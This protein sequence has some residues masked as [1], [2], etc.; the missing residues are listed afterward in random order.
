MRN[1]HQ[2]E[3][4]SGTWLGAAIKAQ[5]LG[6]YRGAE[7]QK[8]WPISSAAAGLGQKYA[9]GCTPAG[10]HRVRALIGAKAPIDSVFVARRLTGETY[11]PALAQQAPH[12]DWILSRIIWLTGAESGYNRGG[13][14]DTLRRFIYIHGT[15]SHEPM[16]VARSH[17]CLRMR[18]RDV[19][20]LFAHCWP[21]MPVLIDTELPC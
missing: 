7:C 4:P 12:R 10:W 3:I 9:S 2:A 21:G 11:T 17:G 6:L 5:T 16:G 14:V 18:N 19:I 8:V 13:S 1:P 15:P 20:S